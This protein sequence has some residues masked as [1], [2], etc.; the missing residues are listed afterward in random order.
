MAKRL[1]SRA[2]AAVHAYCKHHDTISI[3]KISLTSELLITTVTNKFLTG[4]RN[5]A[6][7][8]HAHEKNC[9]NLANDHWSPKYLNMYF[10]GVQTAW[11]SDMCLI[12]FRHVGYGIRCSVTG[13][14]FGSCQVSG[15]L[16][17]LP[18]NC[19]LSLAICLSMLDSVVSRIEKTY[20]KL[21]AVD[22]TRL[23]VPQR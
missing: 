16:A 14:W 20:Q 15:H 17:V 10:C 13:I 23:K 19:Y 6:L 8:A 4:S 21:I 22:C 12:F 2:L 3:A 18:I 1:A 9:Q 7:S 11:R 5:V